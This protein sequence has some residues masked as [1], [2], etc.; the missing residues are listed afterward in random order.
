MQ[1]DARCRQHLFRLQYYDFFQNRCGD[2]SFKN[3]CA[4]VTS[5]IPSD[6][7]LCKHTSDLHEEDELKF[8]HDMAIKSFADFGVGGIEEYEKKS[9]NRFLNSLSQMKVLIV[10]E[11]LLTGFVAPAATVLY[12]DCDMR[13]HTLFQTICRVNWL[14]TD[15]KDKDDRII[16]LTHKEF[17]IVVDFKHLSTRSRMR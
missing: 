14:G 5:S 16:A 17:G 7:D 4:V 1:R 9:K 12:I 3:Q 10:V 11:K 8:K 2:T 13:D 6:D 15:V